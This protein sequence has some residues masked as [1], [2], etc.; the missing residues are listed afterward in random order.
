MA[1]SIERKSREHLGDNRFSARDVPCVIVT[2]DDGSW[3]VWPEA[4]FLADEAA[5]IAQTGN[6]ITPP[7]PIITADEKIAILEKRNAALEAALIEK[8]VLTKSEVDAKVDVKV[9]EAEV[10]KG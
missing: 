7:E 5:C 9:V 2:A 10:V 3:R 4:L 8:A 1:G 6:G